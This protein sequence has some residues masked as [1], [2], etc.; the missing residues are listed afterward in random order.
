MSHSKLPPLAFE[1]SRTFGEQLRGQKILIACS[2]GLDS[3][4]L[5][6]VLVKLAARFQIDLAIAHIHHG[7][8]ASASITRARDGARKFVRALAKKNELPFYSREAS[9]DLTLSSE[10]ELRKF[11]RH[12]F[13]E[14]LKG[15]LAPFDCVALAHHADDLFETRLMRLIRGTGAPGLKAMSAFGD[16]T[17]RLF[18]SHRRSE[19]LAYA[20]QNHLQWLEDPSNKDEA[21][22]RNWVRNQW[23]PLLEAKR[24][25]AARAFARSL[26]L[27][28]ESINVSTVSAAR[29]SKGGAL[30]LRRDFHQLSGAEKRERLASLGR[31]HDVRDFGTSKIIEVLKR[32]E[33]FELTRQRRA[34]FQV[35]GLI[36]KLTP[37]EIEASRVAAAD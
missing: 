26:D 34:T 9:A 24:P 23:L 17:V 14:I 1:I 36:W 12:A 30:L 13:G 28:T 35:G 33:C 11:R 29:H 2:A 27:L 37:L 32:L 10:A 22:F 18:L 8:S 16:K 7:R 6:D 20:K 4:T 19:I 3:T 25:G 21:F 5:V 31:F 15:E